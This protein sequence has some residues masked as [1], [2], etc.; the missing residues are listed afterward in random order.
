MG[1]RTKFGNKRR[2]GYQKKGLQAEKEL[3]SERRVTVAIRIRLCKSEIELTIR[4]KVREL[5]MRRRVCNQK[6]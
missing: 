5:L 6:K 1:N 2:P 4:R 3:N